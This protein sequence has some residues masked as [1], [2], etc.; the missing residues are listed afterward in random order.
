MKTKILA[1]AV[2]FIVAIAQAAL[3][4]DTLTLSWA[5]EDSSAMDTSKSP[6][7]GMTYRI[8]GMAYVSNTVPQNLSLLAIAVRTGDSTTNQLWYGTASLTTNGGFTADVQFPVW[9]VSQKYGLTRQMG[10]ELTLLDVTNGISMTYSAQ[11]MFLVTL[12][13]GGT[14]AGVINISTNLINVLPAVPSVFSRTGPVSAT[15]GDYTAALVGAVPTNAPQYLAG[16]TNG[17]SPT[18]PSIVLTGN[19]NWTLSISSRNGTNGIRFVSGSLTNWAF[20]Q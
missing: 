3:T 7:A 13:M 9:T 12:P 16:V 8:H 1:V 5:R 2:L 20:F 6:L 11:K 15:A 4:P 17:S 18:F 10:V 19:T 14:N